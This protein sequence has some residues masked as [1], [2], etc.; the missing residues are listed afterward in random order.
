MSDR[1]QGDGD[2]IYG[3]GWKPLFQHRAA[4]PPESPARDPG[5]APERAREQARPPLRRS[6]A[7]TAAATAAVVIAAAGAGAVVAHELW[8]PS[9]SSSASPSLGALP[10]VG[11]S[12]GSGSPSNQVTPSPG[13]SGGLGT[14]GGSFGYGSGGSTGGTFG[15][16]GAGSS[17][18][19]AGTSSNVGSI[20]A[21]V[22]PA[23]VDINSTLGYQRGLAAGTGIVVSSDGKVLTNNHVIAGSTKLTAT[24]VG[25]GK[26]YTATV[27]GY[28]VSHD[29]AVLQLQD[30][31]GLATAKIG[32]SSTAKVGQAVVGIGNAG[33]LGGAPA[34][35]GGSITA[36]NQ[37]IEARDDFG[38]TSERLSGLIQVDADIQSGDSGGPLVNGKGEVIGI[39]TAGSAQFTFAARATQA[40]AIP[41]NKAVQIAKQ[42]LSGKGSATVHIGAT[43][44]L[45]VSIASDDTGNGLG[46]FGGFGNQGVPSTSSGA[47]VAGVLSGLPAAKIGLGPGDTIT[48]LNGRTIGSRSGLSTVMVALHPGDTV[49]VDWVDTAGQSHTASVQLTNGPAA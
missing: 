26:T 28:D 45:G 48:S 24:D 33:G 37:S 34:S 16:A 10:S 27:V 47:V 36:L 44:F 6:I 42:I 5:P 32:D 43:G 1:A 15:G 12:G 41:I 49:D 17:G 40:Y 20:A 19:A 3:P 38:G 8:T 25:N 18:S 14:Q 4:E 9:S 2:Q 13:T 30:A 31:S 21:K 46:G 29:I 23:I 7:L 35:A 39:D 22:A 11:S